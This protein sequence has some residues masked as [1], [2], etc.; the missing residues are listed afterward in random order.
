MK[1][2]FLRF[3]KIKRSETYSLLEI[4]SIYENIPTLEKDDLSIEEI[5]QNRAN[6]IFGEKEVRRI[7]YAYLNLCLFYLKDLENAYDKLLTERNHYKKMIS[8]RR[9]VKNIE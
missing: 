6:E 3:F 4:T 8:K 5:S 9:E 1:F 7:I 2:G